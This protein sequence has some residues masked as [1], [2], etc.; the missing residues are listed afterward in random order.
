MQVLLR[1]NPSFENYQIWWPYKK[2]ILYCKK[3]YMNSSFVTT[4]F[5]FLFSFCRN[6]L[7]ILRLKLTHVVVVKHANDMKNRNV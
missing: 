6:N 4:F 5:F 3:L 1:V 2:N 7:R